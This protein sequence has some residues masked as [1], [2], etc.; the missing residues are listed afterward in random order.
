MNKFV[1]RLVNRIRWW[2]QPGFLKVTKA[3]WFR[4][5][6][7]FRFR[8]HSTRLVLL[9]IWY[10]QCHIHPGGWATWPSM[11]WETTRVRFWVRDRTPLSTSHLRFVSRSRPS[12]SKSRRTSGFR[13]NRFISVKATIKLI[14]KLAEEFP[15][16]AWWDKRIVVVADCL[17]LTKSRR[18]TCFK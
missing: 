3:T 14:G 18:G 12:T 17:L 2:V 8:F 6:F 9:N 5:R 4:F 7:Q 1:F 15:W 11:K 16:I 13:R 10:F